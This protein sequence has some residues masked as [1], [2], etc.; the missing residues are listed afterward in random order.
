MVTYPYYS[1][2]G[3]PLSDPAGRWYE[4]PDHSF[5]QPFSG[6]RSSSNEIMG[7]SGERAI[8]VAPMQSGIETIAMH[9]NAVDGLGNRAD[10]HN[11]RGLAIMQNLQDFYRET[12]FTSGMMG[13][14]LLTKHFSDTFAL[15]AEG[16]IEA[17]SK[18]LHS[19]GDEYATMEI[20]YRIHS[21]TWRDTDW[22][23]LSLPAQDGDQYPLTALRG[24]APIQDLLVRFAGPVI[25][26][27]IVNSNHWGF[28]LNLTIPDGQFVTV[29]TSRWESTMPYTNG[30]SWGTSFSGRPFIQQLGPPSG[31]LFTLFTTPIRAGYSA[32]FTGKNTNDKTHC[33]IRT[34]GAYV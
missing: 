30:S 17:S 15:D 19:P 21:G 4:A 31:A 10:G 33:T 14:M 3:V 25:D 22:Q 24:N 20:I 32:A 12:G 16:R 29:N 8:A 18:V 2:N 6:L 26:P 13:P 28:Q 23:E 9:I 11:E 7:V 1:L 34:R 27:K 5:A